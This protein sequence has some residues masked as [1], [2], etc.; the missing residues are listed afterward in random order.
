MNPDDR[1]LA[2]AAVQAVL[3]GA[4]AGAVA[5]TTVFV[6]IDTAYS[7]PAAVAATW[8][9]RLLLVL[10][11]A[12]TVIALVFPRSEAGAG[13]STVD[14]ARSPGL[15]TTVAV[16]VLAAALA[17]LFAF[18]A[19]VA[20]LAG[21]GFLSLI[22]GGCAVGVLLSGAVRLSGRRLPVGL[23]TPFSTGRVLALVAVFVVAFV[24][25]PGAVGS[26]E[27]HIV[28]YGVDVPESDF[29]F[30]Y[31]AVDD[32]WGVVAVTHAGGEPANPERLVVGH[33]EVNESYPDVD[34]VDQYGSGPW[35]GEATGPPADGG[36]NVS[37]VEGDSVRVAVRS[38]CRID[39]LY[40]GSR[41]TSLGG[42]ACP[43]RES[44]SPETPAS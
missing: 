17:G 1:F 41:L 34:G 11:G 23:A 14:G 13:G 39:L 3:L 2:F 42:F 20:A 12:A 37:V 38:D 25:A 26:P 8:L 15:A 5:E 40:S 16:A 9:V 30:E 44:T 31:E 7:G 29:E 43:D 22:S 10:V 6:P 32:D 27:D 4:G 24:F 28:R 35:A 18:V 36:S 21:N 19:L 33:R